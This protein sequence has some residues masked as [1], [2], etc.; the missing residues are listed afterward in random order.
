MAAIATGAG[1]WGTIGKIFSN[2]LVYATLAGIGGYLGGA[3][4]RKMRKMARR[5]MARL[6]PQIEKGISREDILAL[7]PMLRKGVMPMV[8]QALSSGAARYGSSSSKAMGA[9]VQAAGQAMAPQVASLGGQRLFANL[10]A[11]KELFRNY[12]G[13][14]LTG[15]PMAGLPY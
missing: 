8:N 3:E 11:L 4:S 13:T 5:Q 14:A 7:M 1:G 6:Q 12:A 9:G 15:T 2:P 10:E